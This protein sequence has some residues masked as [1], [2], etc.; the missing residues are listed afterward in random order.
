[1]P[2]KKQNKNH[3]EQVSTAVFSRLWHISFYLKKL[4]IFFSLI[5]SY[6]LSLFLKNILISY[7]VSCVEENVA[8]F[9]PFKFMLLVIILQ[10]RPATWTV[11]PILTSP[12]IGFDSPALLQSNIL[13]IAK[14]LFWGNKNS[15]M[16][17]KMITL[18]IPF[19]QGELF[20]KKQKWHSQKANYELEVLRAVV[21]HYTGSIASFPVFKT[22]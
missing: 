21:C 19:L 1:M 14:E 8:I 18:C 13:E 17:F 16:C 4:Q 5:Y 12:V 7:F 11:Y 3:F 6:F 10:F 2:K 15:L 9:W 22:Y 20:I